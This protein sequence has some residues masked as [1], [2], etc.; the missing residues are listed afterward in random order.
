MDCNNVQKLLVNYLDDDLAS[1]ELSKFE[2]HIKT[3]SQTVP[4]Y[5]V[6]I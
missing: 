4:L 5:Y 2:A 3:F 6:L 1:N